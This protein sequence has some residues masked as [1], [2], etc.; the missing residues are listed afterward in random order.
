M[1]VHVQGMGEKNLKFYF[2]F[3]C[4][5]NDFKR[6]LDLFWGLFF[7][8]VAKSVTCPIYKVWAKTNRFCAQHFYP[9]DILFWFDF[10]GV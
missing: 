10:F 2:C 7:F 6:V 8:E 5:K 1:G 3:L 9:L 4:S